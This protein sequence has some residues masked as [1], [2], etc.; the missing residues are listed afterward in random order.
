MTT[1]RLFGSTELATRIER[2]DS[3]LLADAVRAVRGR[4]PQAAF[5]LT[6]GGGI[7]SWAGAGSPLNKVAG[8]GLAGPVPDEDLAAVERAFSVRDTPVQL[9]VANLADPR[10]FA[11]LIRRGYVITGFENVLGLPLAGVRLPPIAGEIQVAES[12]R[13]ELD[14]WLDLLVAGFASPDSQG[15]T[16]REEYPRAVVNQAVRA[17]N[18]SPGFRRFL[19]RRRGEPAG[20]ASLRISDG[21]AQL[22]G[23]ATLPQHRRRGV[24]SALLAWRLALA[25]QAGCDLTVVTTQPGSKSQQNVQRLGFEL[26]YSRAILLRPLPVQR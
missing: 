5:Y 12:G 15:A 2:A 11:Q 20:A 24:Q 4:D 22:T 8:L 6:L 16:W 3:Q 23:S 14:R 21:L 19:A 13:E 1:S 18:A 25:A 7:A 17:L 9:E 26:L 10:L